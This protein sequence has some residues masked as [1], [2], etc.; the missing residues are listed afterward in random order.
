MPWC[1]LPHGSGAWYGQGKIIDTYAGQVDM[2]PTLEHLLALDLKLPSGSAKIA[3]KSALANHS[4]P[5]QHNFVTQNTL[6]LTDGPTTPKPVRKLLILTKPSRRS[7]MRFA[8]PPIPSWRLVDAI[9][10]VTWFAFTRVMT[11]ARST[12]KITPY[13]NSMKALLAIEK[14]K[15]T[16]Q[17]ALTLSEEMPPLW[18]SLIRQAIEHCIPNSSKLAA[19]TKTAVRKTRAPA[20]APQPIHR[21]KSLKSNGL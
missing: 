4:L 7:W 12:L 9:Q 18:I 11:G 16:N 20:L 6:A 19:A 2:L 21:Y 10:T 17:P 5:I 1:S 8:M 14:E 15:A 13:L 3:I